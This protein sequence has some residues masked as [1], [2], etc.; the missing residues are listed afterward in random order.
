MASLNTQ[1]AYRDAESFDDDRKEGRYDRA[2]WAAPARSTI[3]EDPKVRAALDEA[4]AQIRR[5]FPMVD[6]IGRGA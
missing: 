2:D 1:Q 4:M 3:P 6:R 5:A